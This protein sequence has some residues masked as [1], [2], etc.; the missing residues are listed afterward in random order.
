MTPGPAISKNWD[1]KALGQS[2]VLTALIRVHIEGHGVQDTV[3]S[4]GPPDG[5]TQSKTT[6][7]ISANTATS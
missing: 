6:R 2:P 5:T 1:R 3:A 4:K 7:R